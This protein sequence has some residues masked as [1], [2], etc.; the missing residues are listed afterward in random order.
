MNIP[1]ALYK[2]VGP[3]RIDVLENRKIRFTPPLNTNDVFEIRQTF[4]LFAGPNMEKLFRET[5]E[6]ADIDEQFLSAVKNSPLAGVPPNILRET[7]ERT[8]GLKLNEIV[9]PIVSSV[10]NKNLIPKLNSQKSI[11]AVLDNIGNNLICLSLSESPYISPMWAHYSANSNG[12][13]IEFNTDNSFFRTHV[14][15]RSHRLQKILY[16]DGKVAEPMSDPN[17]A[18]ISKQSDWSYEREWRLYNKIED[19]DEIINV[20]NEVIHLVSFPEKI[21]NKIILGLNVTED[22]ILK[23]RAILRSEFS[24]V[25]LFRIDVDRQTSTFVKKQMSI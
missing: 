22:T 14:G 5:L 11:D 7:V 25:E 20:G 1:K 15:N 17:K 3:E 24:N 19:S 4:D 10:L 2:Y 18:F 13:V 23:I 16:F 12:F 8:F 6:N 9:K 21:I